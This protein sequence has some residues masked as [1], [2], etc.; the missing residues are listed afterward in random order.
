MKEQNKR[1]P[2]NANSVQALNEILRMAL[3]ALK[4]DNGKS[5]EETKQEILCKLEE[6]ASASPDENFSNADELKAEVKQK[7]HNFWIC[8]EYINAR[9]GIMLRPVRL[10]DKEDYLQIQKEYS[11]IRNTLVFPTVCESLWNE[12]FNSKSLMFSIIKN[13]IYVGYCGINDISSDSQEIAIELKPEHT[14]KGIG[15]AAIPAMIN[16]LNARLG[17]REFLVR[18]DPFNYASQHLFEKL[19]AVP[20]GIEDGLIHSKEIQKKCEEENLSMLDEKAIQL[21][22]RFGV[23]PE[24][25]LSHVLK[26]SLYADNSPII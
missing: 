23:A 5:F 26:Y 22:Q 12:H 21:A 25:L 16:A 15:T 3:D 18:I 4:E 17:V 14:G 19:G 24:K 10:T 9:N 1:I 20:D 11:P 6:I 8:G 7:K 13:G 2:A